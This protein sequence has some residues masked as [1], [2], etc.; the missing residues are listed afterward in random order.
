MIITIIILS[1]LLILSLIGNYVFWTISKK[2][3]DF[4]VRFEENYGQAQDIMQDL[5]DE[6]QTVLT[7]PVIVDDPVTRRVVE[8]IRDSQSRIIDIA[9][10]IS[11]QDDEEKAEDE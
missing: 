7:T 1:V 10:L 2:L 5:Y 9:K 8:K 6:L 4:V 11:M 3:S